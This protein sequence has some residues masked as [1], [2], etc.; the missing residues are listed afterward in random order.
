[1]S[2]LVGRFPFLARLYDAPVL[3][4]ASL[5]ENILH[6]VQAERFTNN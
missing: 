1:M 6:A 4:K 3:Q 2:D 5:G